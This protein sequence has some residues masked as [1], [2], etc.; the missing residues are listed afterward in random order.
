MTIIDRQSLPS[1][2]NIKIYE[3][4]SEDPSY[5]L[6]T[7]DNNT[8]YL[9]DYK[10]RKFNGILFFSTDGPI[11]GHWGII[12]YLINTLAPS[13][14]SKSNLLLDALYLIFKI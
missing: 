6:G 9:T 10:T 13:N 14:S 7:I 3:D 1:S 2:D 5:F 8:N 12:I 11:F 4:G